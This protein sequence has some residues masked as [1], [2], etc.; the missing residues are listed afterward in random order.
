M[1]DKVSD[2]YR[3]CSD[4]LLL[5]G[6]NFLGGIRL[7]SKESRILLTESFSILKS[8]EEEVL[9]EKA[10]GQDERCLCRVTRLGHR[11]KAISVLGKDTVGIIPNGE[12]V[13]DGAVKVDI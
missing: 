11:N 7:A 5:E 9:E 2:G 1:E 8:A 6:H 4:V 10:Y 3:V 12:E 13:R